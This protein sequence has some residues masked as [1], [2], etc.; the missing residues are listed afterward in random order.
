MTHPSR[1]RGSK[2]KVSAIRRADPFY[3]REVERYAAPLPSREYILQLIAEAGCPV[4]ADQFAEQ[5]E[6]TE[7]ERELFQRRLGA[8]QRDGQLMLNR[9]R[10]LCLPDK[11]DLIKG[12]VEGHPDGFGF[13]APDEGGAD[14]F[15]SPKEM[16]RV[17]HGDR[18][19][20]RVAGFD[21]RGRRE[22]KIVEVLEHVNR[23]VVGRYYTEGGVGFLIAENRRINQDILVPPGNEGDAQSGQ[24]VTVEIVTQPGA[25]NEAVGRVTE[26]LGSYTGPG[27]EIE[28]ALRKHDLPHVFPP[29]VEKQAAALPKKVLKKDLAGREDI[30]D[31]PLVTI[32]GETARDFDDAVY[33]EPLGRSG[34]R[35]VVAIADVS[36]YVKPGDA[37]DTEAYTRGTSV[38]FPRRVIPML[39]EALSNGLCSLNPEVDRLSMVCDMRI[40]TAGSIKE[41][42]FYPAV[43]YSHA[44]LTYN[45]VWDWLSGEVQPDKQQARLMPHLQA[46]DKLF[47]TLLKARAKRGAIDFGSTETQMLFDDQGK[48]KAIVPV[49]RNDAHRIIEECML[50]AN[51]CASDFLLQNDQPSLYRVHE[52]PTAEKLTALRS[53]MA[54]FGLDLP[55]GDKPHAKDFGALLEKI[56]PRPD[57]G[58]LQTVMLRSLKQAIYTPDNK[59]HFGLAYDG[60]TH[61]TS[62]IRR[63]PDLL[64]HRA[65]KAVLQ[66]SKLPGKGLQEIGAHCS[67]TERRA[68]DATRDVDAW[69]KT[70][71]M[72]EH[73][74]EE[75]DGTVSAVTSFGIFVALD[76]IFT[77]GLVHVSEL[78]QDYFH[79]DQAKHLML[80][81]RTGKRYRLGDRVRIKVM[82]ADIETSK[83]DFSLV[84]QDKD[85]PALDMQRAFEKQPYETPGEAPRQK[86]AK[87]KSG[88]G[89]DKD[90]GKPAKAKKKSSSRSKSAK[91]SSEQGRTPSGRGG[92]KP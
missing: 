12:R 66:G 53:F 21:K 64:V 91:T 24:V 58:L 73:I 36:H 16:H 61:F 54:E 60:Y 80:G 17:L 1:S 72:R 49:V 67:M 45:Q 55:G 4:D 13:V 26:V 74:G 39:P 19:L 77:E 57:A 5:L 31:L 38:Y 56:K 78:G 8:M 18:V 50:S 89:G 2:N 15:L 7:A 40:T 33:C 62:P 27:M 34:F 51:V 11:L 32:D 59:G 83:V 48:I 3:E 81:E 30:R 37:L 76:D 47:R 6:I 43:I 10:Q 42:R 68:D 87:A 23:F 52:G 75:Y 46:L 92:K 69:L 70:Y 65:I 14:L 20:V 86:S 44:R 82:R 35:L 41:Y 79:Y 88:K 29:D 90:D 85:N 9:K 28:I 25:H 22:G 84:E 71:F 63:Y